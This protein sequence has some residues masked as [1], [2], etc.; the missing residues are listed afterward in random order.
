MANKFE[1]TLINI[2][3]AFEHIFTGAGKIA[4]AAEPFVDI[5]FPALAPLYNAAATGAACVGTLGHTALLYR[6]NEKLDPDK[7]IHLPE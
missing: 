5:A 6:P 3:K 7:R 4:V 1:H 2:G